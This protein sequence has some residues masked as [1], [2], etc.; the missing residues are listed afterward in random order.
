MVDIRRGM[1]GK[2]GVLSEER[3]GTGKQGAFPIL[4]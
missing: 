3:G 2:E 4:K 1:P